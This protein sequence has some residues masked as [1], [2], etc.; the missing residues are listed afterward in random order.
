MSEISG[1]VE[2]RSDRRRGK[3]T[4]VVNP[5][6]KDLEAR[7][8]HVP[9]DKHLLVHAGDR[10]EAGDPL[11][12]GPLV[13]HDILAIRG[14]EA[15][16]VYLLLEVQAVYRSQN[17]SI[18]DKHIEIMINQMLRKVKVE[19]PGDTN[20]LPGEVIDKFRFRTENE[21][22]GRSL[23]I[24]DPGDSK[25]I[26]GQIV[27]KDELSNTNE[28]LETAGKAPAKGKKPKPA[29]AATVLLGIT[30]AALQCESFLSAAS[31]QETTKVLTEAALSSASD[32]LA[33]LKE[34]V[35]LGHL[36]PA[37]TG[38]RSHQGVELRHLGQPIEE[39]P[40]EVRM[41]ELPGQV[42]REAI[43]ELQK[44]TGMV[45][46]EG[47]VGIAGGLATLIL[48]DDADEDDDSEDKA[49]GPEESPEA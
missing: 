39:P 38:F 46:N 7:E 31:F 24:S 13:P 10:V 26:E 42:D 43:A 27:S 11:C 37:G 2:I 40:T 18:N 6:S 12:D 21:R 28:E 47:G 45:Q 16:Y 35:I 1:V 48:E 19:Q 32:R 49:D 5:D 29:T 20:L 44:A 34:N 41:P 25:Y 14:E 4:I 23:K 30:K 3:M 33:G 8:H 17:V 9:Q 36:I 22:L 15:L